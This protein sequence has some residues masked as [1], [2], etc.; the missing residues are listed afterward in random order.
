MKK[1]LFII[2]LL[3]LSISYSFSS[4]SESLTGDSVDDLSSS[5]TRSYPELVKLVKETKKGDHL[6]FKNKKEID[7]LK[8]NGFRI[9]FEKGIVKMPKEQKNVLFS[10]CLSDSEE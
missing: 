7:I 9:D 6:S 4:E 10:C 5:S 2:C 8:R 3:F 1:V